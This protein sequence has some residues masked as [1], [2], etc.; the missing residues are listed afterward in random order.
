MTAHAILAL[1]LLAPPAPQAEDAPTVAKKLL[2]T[3][4][5]LFDAKDAASL[6]ATFT[7]DAEVYAFTSEGGPKVEKRTGRAEIESLYRDL[8]KGDGS[9]HARNDIESATFGNPSTLIIQGKFSINAGTEPIPFVQVRVKQ[10]G[11]W[12]MRTL[13]L[14]FPR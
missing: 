8:F 4:A 3:G 5:A 2:E 6:A 13:Q 10:D 14:F 12:R 11:Q 7:E 1:V 9:F